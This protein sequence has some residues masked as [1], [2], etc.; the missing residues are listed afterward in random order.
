MTAAHGSLPVLVWVA[1]AT[2]LALAVLPAYLALWLGLRRS[3]RAAVEDRREHL[4]RTDTEHPAALLA[5]IQ[6]VIAKLREQ[7]KQVA[8]RYQ[9]ERQRALSTARLS[10]A[11]IRNMP[12]G[13]LLIN[14]SGL[15]TLSNR[16]AERVLGTAGLAYRNYRE[17]FG[18]DA[19]L[20]RLI[21]ACL[22]QRATFLRQEILHR[23]PAGEERRLGTTISPVESEEPERA[24]AAGALCLLSDL[25]E[26]A[27]LENQ[28]RLR[29]S[30]AALGEMSAGIAHEFKNSLGILSGYAQMLAR[31]LPPGE[32]AEAA[33]HV[34]REARRLAQ[35]VRELLQFARP[36]DAAEQPVALGALIEQI[37][38]GEREAARDVCFCVEGEF[39]EVLGDERLLR[40]ALANLLRNA[41]E[42]ARERPAGRV[43]VRGWLQER[44]GRPGACLSV[45][46]DGPGISP[47]ALPKLFLPFF[48]TKAGGSGLGLAAVQK[49]VLQHG[50]CLEARNRTAGGAEFA[51]WLPIG[52][53]TNTERLATPSS[54]V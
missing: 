24:R 37:V 3:L 34:V 23:T 7:E 11:V 31:E 21:E 36:V 12:T 9:L 4:P 5:A 38:A 17:V 30:L 49:I 35:V 14:A 28:M 50:G 26:L 18:A 2:A 43:L 52:G 51:L 39:P 46:D 6:A 29:E 33:G 54:R 32:P 48:T 45:A 53:R 15:V 27:A 22:E 8:R 41:S 25:T 19:P 16:A 13:L 40:Q 47:E 20:A 1:A 44:M 42:A 10:D